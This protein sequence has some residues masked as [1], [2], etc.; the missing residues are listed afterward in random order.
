[1]MLRPVRISLALVFLG[2]LAPTVEARTIQI[3]AFGDSNT[4][5]FLTPRVE[6]YPNRLEKLL[7]AKGYDVRV[8]NSGVSGDTSGAG[9]ARMDREV[10]PGT[11]IAIVFFG[12]NDIRFGLGMTRLEA[13]LDEM[14]GRLRARDIAV[15]LCGQHGF[16]FS[17]IAWKHG[18]VYFPDFFAGTAI[19][20]I[21]KPEYTR[22][23]DPL[24][25]LNGAGYAVVTDAL[26]PVVE[27][28]VIRAGGSK[29]TA[30]Q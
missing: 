2:V 3:V 9:L 5:G 17:D 13:N 30:A 28:L 26:L 16:D 20:G 8:R 12:R 19:A 15:V 1:M 24:R 14:V 6:S 4:A 18:A 27:R 25:H 22:F 11:D 7:R 29:S 21:K 23:F 10:P